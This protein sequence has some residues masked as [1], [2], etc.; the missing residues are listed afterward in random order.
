[1]V[2]LA[3]IDMIDPHCKCK[4]LMA[5]LA[6]RNRFNSLQYRTVGLDVMH[7]VWMIGDDQI[8]EL[9]KFMIILRDM[10]SFK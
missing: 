10:S 6:D 9:S 4:R 8:S 7:P 5:H 3:T 1:M 2:T